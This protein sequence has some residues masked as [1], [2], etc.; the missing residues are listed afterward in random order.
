MPAKLEEVLPVDGV[1]FETRL[2]LIDDIT[3]MAEELCQFTGLRNVM[4]RL[5]AEPPS[6]IC[7]FHVDTVTPGLPPYG[8]L[9]V[10]NGEP[11]RYV[12]SQDVSDMGVFYRY[13]DK[14]E[15]LSARWREAADRGDAAEADLCRSV[16]RD[17]D[18][19]LPFLRDGASVHLVP[20]GAIVA[21]R[22][23]DSR[24][25]W[26]R[27]PASRTWL[28]CSP[29]SGKARLVVNLTPAKNQPGR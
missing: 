28:H 9:K 2:A 27:H 16:V 29:M 3:A 12:A 19:G 22:H 17:L 26:S 10:Y 8:L 1:D 25:H 13:L 6:E 15:R 5:L 11:T 23:L 14:R 24:E 18:G 21:F 20:Q 7:G 4:L